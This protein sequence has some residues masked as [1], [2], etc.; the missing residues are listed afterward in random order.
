LPQLTGKLL[1]GAGWSAQFVNGVVEDRYYL[2]LQNGVA[3]RLREPLASSAGAQVEASKLLPPDTY[4]ITR[5]GYRDPL[6]AWRGLNAAI[7][8][9]LDALGAVSVSI[10]LK[11]A[12]QPYGIEDPDS[13]L[14]SIGSDI[15][16]AS[17][18]SE[19]SGTVTIVEVKDETALRA[20]VSKRLG[21]RPRTDRVGEAELLISRDEAR[22][23]ASFIAGRLIMG[24]EEN[25]RRCLEARAKGQ[26]LDAA[27]AFQ[28]SLGKASNSS[29]PPSVI[30]FTRDNASALSVITAIASQPA[31][32]TRPFNQEETERTLD[33]LP[34][35][36][37]ETNLVEGGF[38]K[39]TRSAFGQF[40]TLVA[41]FS[42]SPSQ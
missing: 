20:F 16:T 26:T 29:T 42:P 24:S 3:E 27:A 35:T 4:R 8:S 34:Y 38:E 32:R 36:I 2:A 31:A 12:L 39:R 18:S 13:F 25:V 10:L 22:G 30:T 40:G 1:G 15:V 19:G 41:Q 5:Y 23:A 7:S 14:A 9:Q 17:L 28:N 37:S 6:E 21:P 33:Q 11:A